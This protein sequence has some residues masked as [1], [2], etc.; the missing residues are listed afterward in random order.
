MWIESFMRVM[1]NKITVRYNFP[2]SL[3]KIKQGWAWQVVREWGKD[4][5]IDTE[6]LGGGLGSS[7]DYLQPPGAYHVYHIMV[8]RQVWLSHSDKQGG[9]V[10]YSWITGTGLANPHL[11]GEQS[12]DHKY[13]RGGRHGGHFSHAPST[14]APGP[15]EGFASLWPSLR[16]PVFQELCLLR[17]LIP[18]LVGQLLWDPWNPVH[19]REQVAE[20][21]VHLIVTRKQEQRRAGP[22][23][24]IPFRSTP[25]GI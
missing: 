20:N 22:G 2:L 14:P 6:K 10:G 17:A 25:P 24:H 12:S 7:V 13:P 18:Q 3:A 4:R 11:W 1:Q 15:E 9:F 19:Y 5:H 8:S 23:S 21:M 16:Q